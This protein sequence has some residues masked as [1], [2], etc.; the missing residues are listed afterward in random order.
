RLRG[1][2]PDVGRRSARGEP[3]DARLVERAARPAM[4]ATAR[5]A[6]RRRGGVR[7]RR[8]EDEAEARE[9][10]EPLLERDVVRAGESVEI[11][12]RAAAPREL[13]QLQQRAGDARHRHVAGGAAEPALGD[14]DE[15]LA[16]VA[17]PL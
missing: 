16:V 10:D 5:E 11:E 7:G 4:Q 14:L 2:V 13:E 3:Q 17:E 15:R 6:L 9:R 8:G 1:E 12:R